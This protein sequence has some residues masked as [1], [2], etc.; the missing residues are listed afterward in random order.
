MDVDRVNNYE[1]LRQIA[2]GGMGVVFLAHQTNLGRDVAL[3]R[4]DLDSSDP[5]LAER[6]MRE[7]RLAAGLE[8]PNIVTLLDF[9]EH[10]GVPYLAMEYVAGGTL[11][12]HIGSLEL[13][14]V[15]GVLE[16]VLAGL[17]HAESH[18]IAHRDLKP[19]N[20]LLTRGGVVKITDFGIARAY[21]ALTQ[22]LT[23]TGMAMG[24]PAYMAPEQALNEP[25]GPFSDIYAVG[26]I[27]YE[28]LAGR[29]P[30]PGT[31]TPVVVLYNHVHTSPPSLAEV[32]PGVPARLCQWV[33]W[34][35]AKA[36]TDRPFSA[37]QAREAIEDLAVDELGPLWRRAAPIASA[38]A[39]RREGYA[40]YGRGS[41]P[42]TPGTAPTPATSYPSAA[43]TPPAVSTPPA[44]PP[45]PAVSA[46]AATPPPPAVSTPAESPASRARAR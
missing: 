26:V 25:L 34:L 31:D 45:P 28:M 27:A 36:P 22:R 23:R 20:L 42:D 2:R 11:R 37:R 13:P 4:L 17:E 7:A 30:F 39:E 43:P 24:T 32:A 10:Q 18:G 46:P 1:V 5:T 21:N 6:F 16:G 41:V 12:A 38:S 14:Q 33:E 15:F 19:E 3:K 35:L 40:T 29:P 9:F 8:H 44:T